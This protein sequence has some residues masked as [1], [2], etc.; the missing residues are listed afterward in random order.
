MDLNHIIR[1]IILGKKTCT[2]GP[3][4]LKPARAGYYEAQVP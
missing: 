3:E 1:C 2:H 4:V